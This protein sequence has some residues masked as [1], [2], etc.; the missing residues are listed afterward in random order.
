MTLP[1][2]NY[3]L[4]LDSIRERCNQVYSKAQGQQ[5]EYFDIDESKLANVIDHVE[6]VT[7]RRFS[8]LSVIPPHSRLRHFSGLDGLQQQWQGVERKEQARRLIDLVV[9]SVLLDAGAGQAWKYQTTDNRAVGRSEGLAIASQDMFMQGY[10]SS[11]KEI[12]DRVDD[13]LDQYIVDD[14]VSIDHLWE[15]VMSLG[16]MWSGRIEIDGVQLGDVWPC[17]CL[18]DK[19]NHENLVPFHKLSQWLTYSLVE[20]LEISLGIK[21]VGTEKLTGLPEYRNGGLLIDHGLLKLKPAQVQRGTEHGEEFPTFDGGDPLIVEWRALTVVYMDII[22][23]GLEKKVGQSLA[24]AQ[25]L[26]G[27]TW[28]AGREVA[29]K[30]RPDLAGPPIVTKSDGTLF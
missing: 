13:F 1:Q 7:K 6:S 3:L 8:D 5:L 9:V 11:A 23:K 2:K 10:F 30:L 14:T 12:P 18:Q 19:G 22:H 27:G 16:G 17:T 26:E 28:T 24:L 20:S 25:V 15:A 4:T 21:V 29:A